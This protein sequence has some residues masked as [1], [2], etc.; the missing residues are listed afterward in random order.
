MNSSQTR[1]RPGQFVKFMLTFP[2]LLDILAPVVYNKSI[3]NREE[4]IMLNTVEFGWVRVVA[5]RPNSRLWS[6]ISLDLAGEWEFWYV[7]DG[8]IVAYWIGD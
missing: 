2:K 5:E 1:G 8:E 7:A 3:K 6:L 4:K